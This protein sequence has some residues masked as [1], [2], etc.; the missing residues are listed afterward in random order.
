MQSLCKMY[1]KPQGGGLLPPKILL[2]FYLPGI[3]LK[4]GS[5]MMQT[6]QKKGR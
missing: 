6:Y 1:V 5:D 4:Y 2:D 3:R